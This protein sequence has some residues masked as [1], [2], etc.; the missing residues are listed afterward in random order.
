MSQNLK[1]FLKE[2]TEYSARQLVDGLCQVIPGRST[3]DHYVVAV[4]RVAANSFVMELD[5]G[6]QYKFTCEKLG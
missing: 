2:E 1:A 3:G 5:D 4:S 6:S